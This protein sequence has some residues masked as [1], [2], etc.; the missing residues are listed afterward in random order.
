M[1]RK[2]FFMGLCFLCAAGLL[3][4]VCYGF[5]LLAKQEAL[6]AVFDPDCEITTETKTLKGTTLSKVKE[7]LGG[8]LVY[9]QEG[10]ESENVTSA[11]KIDF[12][13][14]SKNGDK[15]GIAIV[16][17]EPGKWGPVEFMVALGPEGAV[18]K[19]RVMSY[20]EKRGRPIA[21]RSFM[22]QYQGKTSKDPLKVG[23][24]ITG[25]SGATISSRA[26]TFAVRKAIAL[27]EELYLQ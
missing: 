20:Q 2:S 23:K 16:D 4:A 3:T 22:R 5:V 1:F 8:K 19:V 24:D 17:V 11:T 6:K 14:A 25:I 13:V 10:S 27:Y 12:H 9:Y 21:R 15:I 18:K 26:A 7:R